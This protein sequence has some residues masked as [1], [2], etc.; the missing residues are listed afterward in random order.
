M[1]NKIRWSHFLIIS[2]LLAGGLILD[3]Q[4]N[5]ENSVFS[6]SQL[7]LVKKNK[8]TKKR[9]PA[10]TKAVNISQSSKKVL[11][12]TPKTKK[13]NQI[14]KT[15]IN[16]HTVVSA[17]TNDDTSNTSHTD[18]NSPEN[19]IIETQSNL[20]LDIDYAASLQEKIENDPFPIKN[21]GNDNIYK[22]V[23]KT[24]R[25]LKLLYSPFTD[26]NYGPF[27][28]SK[29]VYKWPYPTVEN[30][31]Q[32]IVALK[33]SIEKEN[34]LKTEND[35]TKGDKDTQVSTDKKASY[36]STQKKIHLADLYG[37]KYSK[38]KLEKYI[39]ESVKNYKDAYPQMPKSFVETA[40]YNMTNALIR[41]KDFTTAFPI[42]KQLTKNEV[43]VHDQEIRNTILE[44]YFLSGRYKKAD[45]LLSVMIQDDTLVQQPL[46]FKIRTGDNMF[47]LNRFQD[48]SEWYQTVLK[49]QKTITKAEQL[50][51]LY[52]A[53]SLHQ[54]GQTNPA[55]RIYKAMQPVFVGTIYESIV[56]FRVT[57]SIKAKEKIIDKTVDRDIASWLK[58]EL[59]S[60][61]FFANPN[62]FT[63][64]HF[65]SLLSS[66]HLSKELR[67]RVILLQAYAFL[68]ENKLYNAID[69]FHTLEITAKNRHIRHA[70]NQMVIKTLFKKGFSN[71]N[72]DDAFAFIRHLMNLKYNL[73]SYSPDKIYKV[74]YHNLDLVG[75]ENASAELTL[76]IIDQSVHDRK[77][78]LYIQFKLAENMYDAFAYRQSIKILEQID[79][80]LL[81]PKA[82]E[83]YYVL[84]VDNLLETNQMIL[85]LDVLE[86]W[87][88]E[89][90]TPKQS[91]WI[92]L[93]KTEILFDFERYKKAMAVINETIGKGV[94]NDVPKKYEDII[95]PLLAYQVILANKL[96]QNNQTLVSFYGHQNLIL[97]SD[98]KSQAI[99]SAISAAMAMNKNKDIKKLM[100]IAKTQL[101]DS[102]YSWINKWTKGEMWVNQIN[103]YLDKSTIAI[104]EGRPQ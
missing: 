61:Q 83:K 44:F 17:D 27:S 8:A 5:A 63:S 93:K 101:D 4:V 98:L 104:N 15:E 81:N 36:L 51:W 80:K 59:L 58:I 87:S 49:P 29:D 82:K 11:T 38:T 42:I 74:L 41:S 37:M 94:L 39:Q 35:E 88:K 95:T 10:R 33:K 46:S 100:S 45:D 9:R 103:K 69:K 26:I 23:A 22:Q 55:K 2:L 57:E 52:L 89:G 19:D 70:L 25:P 86:N 13:K 31:T 96:G 18:P 85:A 91:Y 16:K 48:A 54:L 68:Q 77:S 6:R 24:P 7:D 50:S 65:L 90:T 62:L 34:Q 75:L 92:A 72:S 64:D 67:E 1:K 43:P 32:R 79:K 30:I 71:D 53:E 56:D 73:K 76:K 3:H 97:N 84:L 66:I 14:K 20:P 60:E 21:L 12:K 102:T 99:L 78:R 40:S 47:F 28:A